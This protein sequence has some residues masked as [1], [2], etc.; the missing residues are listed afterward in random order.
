MSLMTREALNQNQQA[1]IPFQ[2][3]AGSTILVTGAAG[4]IGGALCRALSSASQEYELHLKI[5]VCGRDRRALEAIPHTAILVGD[6]RDP[7]LFFGIDEVNY[8]FH[9]AAITKSAEMVSNPVNVMITAMDGTRNVLELARRASCRSAVFLSS[10]EVYGQ[11]L[12]GQVTEDDLGYLDL[13]SARS[14]YPESKRFCEALCHAYYAQYH[15]PVKIAR[16]AQTFGAGTPK[17]DTRV[18]AQFSRS[19]IAGG[20]IELHTD[21]ASRGNYC[22]LSDTVCGLLTIL[23]RGGGGEVYNIANPAASTTIREMAELVANDVAGGRIQ[24]VVKIP[25]DVEKRGY[26]PA[27]GFRLNVDKLMSLGWRPQLGLAD[28]Y[29]QMIAEWR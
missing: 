17:T 29:R 15:V 27:A 14:S 13:A 2:D 5:I 6:V 20:D 9:C 21:G 18:F 28:M 3:L 8:I 19:A 4:L 22:A 12:D 11:G 26:A 10:M 24:V 25:P 1:A 16:L 23:L 7:A